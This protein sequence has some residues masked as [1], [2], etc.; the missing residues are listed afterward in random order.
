MAE[1]LEILR[2][3]PRWKALIEA[4]RAELG[5]SMK[6]YI[7]RDGDS[8]FHRHRGNKNGKTRTGRTVVTHS[9]MCCGLEREHDG[10][11][12]WP[13]TSLGEA[14]VLADPCPECFPAAFAQHRGGRS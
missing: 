1:Q 12:F 3:D 10:L 13:G 7:L 4:V 14:V 6:V 11:W 2:L 9:V 8:V 5:Y